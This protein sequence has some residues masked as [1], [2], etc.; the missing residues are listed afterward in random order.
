L[1]SKEMPR[2]FDLIAIDCDGTILDSGKNVAEGAREAVAEARSR[3]VE[4]TLISGRN[5]GSM[6]F[7]IEEV[8]ITAPVIGGG[9]ALSMMC[10]TVR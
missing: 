9:G 7:I 2:V 5:Y 10:G 1:I 3:G 6:E 8:G 4:V